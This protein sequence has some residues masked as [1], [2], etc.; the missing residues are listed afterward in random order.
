MAQIEK[1]DLLICFHIDERKIDCV[2]RETENNRQMISQILSTIFASQ[3]GDRQTLCSSQKVSINLR[4]QA[5]IKK[6]KTLNTKGNKPNNNRKQ[7]EKMF[8]VNENRKQKHKIRKH[9]KRP[10]N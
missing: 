7:K 5:P 4:K 3:N 10:A 9:R 2:W 8:R 1:L 6:Q